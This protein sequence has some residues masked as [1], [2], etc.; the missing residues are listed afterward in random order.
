MIRHKV[1]QD[2]KLNID[3]ILVYRLSA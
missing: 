2:S 3:S 1:S